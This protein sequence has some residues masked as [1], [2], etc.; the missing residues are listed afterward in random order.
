MTSASAEPATPPNSVQPTTVAHAQA[1]AHVA[2]Q[3]VGE[4]HDAVGHPAVEHQLAGEDEERDR[5]EA[6][7]LHP[8]D[9]LLEDDGD[10][11]A[12]IQDGGDRGQADR[13]RNRHA[14]QQ[15]DG[16][17][18]GEYGQFHAGTTSSLRSSAITCSSEN[19]T[20][21]TPATTSAR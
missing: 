20:I 2:D 6:E 10:R 21:R 19:I 11:E 9:H 1:A 7:H 3:R 5:Q 18:D 15:Q 13:E 4:A 14:Q 12:G 16:E 8:A 17:S